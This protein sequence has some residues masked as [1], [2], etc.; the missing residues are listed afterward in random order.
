[1]GGRERLGGPLIII[2]ICK[3]YVADRRKL[4]KIAIATKRG[5]QIVGKECS[6]TVKTE[7][8]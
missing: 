6:G 2:K 5:S 1:M 8:V 3:D 4:P 7:E